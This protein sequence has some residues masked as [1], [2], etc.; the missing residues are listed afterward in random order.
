[1]AWP[2]QTGTDSFANVAAN[3]VWVGLFFTSADFLA[4][5]NDVPHS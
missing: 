4:S 2:G 3:A 1:M 5:D